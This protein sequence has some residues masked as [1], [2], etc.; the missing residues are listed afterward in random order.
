MDEKTIEPEKLI[1]VFIEDEMRKSY[2]AYSMSMITA[3]ALP[4]VRDGLKPVH[5]RVLM[6]MSDIGLYHNKPT[7]K[8]A[9]VVGH[10]M[11]K[12]H[13][14][15]D[16]AIYDTL[17]RMAQDFSL[18]YPMVYGQGNFGSIDGDPAA[19]YRY[20]E[21]RMTPLAEEMLADIEKDTVN[22]VPNYDDSLEEPS[23]LPA[24]MPFLL[25][26]GSTGIAVGMATNMAPHN[27]NEIIDAI[28]ACVDNP[29]ISIMD[30]VKIVPGPDFPTGG[31]I[32]GRSG[33]LEAYKTGNGK[34]ILRAKTN[35]EKLANDREQIVI[36][37]IPYM[38]NKS[39]LLEKMGQLVR[40]KV[41]EGISFIRDESDRTGM[42]VVIG[43]K[44]DA[45]A[46]VILN[47][48]FKFTSLQNT[49]AINNLALV[50]KQPRQL[51]LKE[52]ITYFIEHRHEVVTRRTQFDLNK[53]RE[54]AHILEGLK[55]ALDNIDA[56]IAIIR[57]SQS[58]E[59]ASGQLQE[60]FSLSQIQAQAI[61]EMKLSRLTGLE[62]DKIEAELLE[63]KTTIKN[64]EEILAL[65]EKR[66]AIIKEELID[67]K[68]RFGDPRRTEIVEASGDV[69]IEDLI[70]D[71]DMVITM[72][73]AGY[74]KRTPVTTYRT[75][76][77][78]GRGV[79][80]MDSKDDDFV[81]SLFVAS[82][83][84]YILFFTSE[85]RCY[86]LKVYRIPE[87]ERNSRGK[88][89]VNLL[90]LRPDETI[91]AFV[92]VKEFDET[93]FIITV[94]QRGV[95][96]KQPLSSY[97][98]IRKDGI[99]AI[100]L[101]EGDR[102]MECKLTNGDNDIILGTREG[103]AI[104][105]HESA[106]RELGRNTRGVR[107]IK[108]I[109]DDRVVGMI[110]V[111]E[112]QQVLTVT[113]NGYGKRTQVSEYRKTNRGGSG[114]INI[115]KSDRNGCVVS[116]K[117]VD[118]S[119]DIMLMTKNGIIIRCDIDKISTIGRNTQGVRLINIDEGDNV[120]DMAI[121]DKEPDIQP[122]AAVAATEEPGAGN[123]LPPAIQEESAVDADEP[124]SPVS[125]E[126]SGSE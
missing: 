64:L 116:L 2:L 58:V 72:S 22:L 97:S 45:F 15:G 24:K 46:D 100:S 39:A 102:M 11:A 70:A 83:H 1:P 71:E 79:L 14:H 63:L 66:L 19:A 31:V 81:E 57:A 59:E 26:N 123:P 37:E 107:G 126:D 62:R 50:N 60:R 48:L 94:T 93:H 104:R 21:C 115:K 41:I 36:T 87:T 32:Y 74:I 42:R 7:K 25:L 17:V 56:I 82:A 95:V 34:V 119:C 29:D 9:N 120:V 98:N 96:N 89:I 40:D 76:G 85:G 108:L 92:V 30:L 13:P 110:I 4:D 75:Q 111:N 77:R 68:T 109:G 20:T 28:V 106:A 38:V 101:D 27:M 5:R 105:F 6:G 47:Q 8:C 67:L 78:G 55:I 86:W 3:R 124:E 16:S 61:L 44:K 73:H 112:S 49:F 35:M 122:E 53:A 10:V 113:E 43:I 114:I 54:R 65:R 18:R 52:L 69:E 88:P 12:Y 125:P 51:N 84:S 91:A 121:C 23:V 117:S 90:N 33:I 118:D 99:N 80:G 103:Q